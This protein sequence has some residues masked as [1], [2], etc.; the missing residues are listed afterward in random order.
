MRGF[1]FQIR[2]HDGNQ[3]ISQGTQVKLGSGDNDN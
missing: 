3:G 2:F 1:F